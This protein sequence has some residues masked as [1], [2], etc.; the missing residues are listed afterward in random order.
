MVVIKRLKILAAFSS[1]MLVFAKDSGG[2]ILSYL[3][4]VYQ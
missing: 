2:L 3:D 1:L 4:L